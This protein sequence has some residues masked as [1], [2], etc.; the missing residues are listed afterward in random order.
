MRT[1][2]EQRT[3][4]GQTLVYFDRAS[5]AA[6]WGTPRD[7]W[8]FDTMIPD[9]LQLGQPMTLTVQL[10]KPEDERI[11][12]QTIVLTG[13][14]TTIGAHTIELTL[15]PGERAKLV[16]AKEIDP[17]ANTPRKRPPLYA[18]DADR[19]IAWQLYWRGEQFWSGGEIW[20][21][22][23]EMRTSFP[24]T[25]NKEFLKYIG[26]RTRMPAGRRYFVVTDAGRVSSVKG[27]LPTDRAKRTFQVLDTTSNKFSLGAFDL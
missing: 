10:R 3:I 24:P 19:L 12:E 25:N 8:A 20:D 18:I 26:D 17:K 4:Y 9:D 14:V 1:Y 6:D 15:A 13:A 27:L 5:L 7:T 2:Y 21:Y 16:R 11:I 22:L 23:P